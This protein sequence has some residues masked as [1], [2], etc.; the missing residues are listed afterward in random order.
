MCQIKSI[1]GI[2]PVHRI[3]I[4]S[5]ATLSEYASLCHVDAHTLRKIISVDFLQKKKKR[6]KKQTKQIITKS[7]R[8]EIRIFQRF[9]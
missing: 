5:Y 4:I 6:R 2:F 9:I 7:M 1:F 8:D 3:R